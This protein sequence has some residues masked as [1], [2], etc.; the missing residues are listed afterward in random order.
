MD[1]ISFQV[2]IKLF[3]GKYLTEEGFVDV[4]NRMKFYIEN[5]IKIACCRKKKMGYE[6]KWKKN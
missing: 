2:E 3:R 6:I 1:E 4:S 5:L